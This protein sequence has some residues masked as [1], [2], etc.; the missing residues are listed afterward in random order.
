M[1]NK[2]ASVEYT[3]W[4]NV[5]SGDI[6]LWGNRDKIGTSSSILKQI[7]YESRTDGQLSSTELD[8]VMRMKTEY[9]VNDGSTSGV[10]RFIQLISV[11]PVVLFLWTQGGI[12]I[13][14][15]TCK[16][17][18]VTWDAT[19][20]AA[21]TRLTDKA[22]YYYELT[23]WI[24]TAVQISLPVA[25]MKS[26]DQTQP[27]GQHWMSCFRNNEKRIYGA[28]NLSHPVQIKNDCA[29]VFIWQRCRYLVTKL[30]LCFWRDLGE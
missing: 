23:I 29:M 15:D 10:N 12:R 22:L 7:S 25:I 18:A 11:A 2:S 30:C 16:M 9:L 20:D 14:H 21:K 5:K 19:S 6:Y 27:T 24:P 8:S 4:I 28:S 3:K 1:F 17:D 13:F 26:C